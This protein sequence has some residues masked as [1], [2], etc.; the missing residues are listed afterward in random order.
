MD[1]FK[2]LDF[3][4]TRLKVPTEYVLI[5]FK[6]AMLDYESSHD[7]LFMHHLSEIERQNHCRKFNRREW[8]VDLRPQRR[9][10]ICTDVR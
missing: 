8:V 9:Y 2:T 10:A 1:E 7:N 5:M 6:Y 4:P 3:V